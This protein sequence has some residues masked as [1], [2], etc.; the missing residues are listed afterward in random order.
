[1]QPN[2]LIDGQRVWSAVTG[3]VFFVDLPPGMHSVFCDHETVNIRLDASESRYVALE[4][5]QV[6]GDILWHVRP[7]L[8]DPDQGSQEIENLHYIGH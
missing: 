2:I 1:M 5:Y 6:G 7:I 4:N 3:E 8:V